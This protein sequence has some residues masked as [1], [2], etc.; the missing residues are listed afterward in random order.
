MGSVSDSSCR[1]CMF[2]SGVYPVA[3]HNAVFSMT[4]SLLIA[5]CLG[6][7]F[8][9]LLNGMVLFSVVGGALLDILCMVFQRVCVLY[10]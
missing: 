9:L 6:V 4:S 3:V 7:V 1:Y 5:I 2:V 10:L 8:I